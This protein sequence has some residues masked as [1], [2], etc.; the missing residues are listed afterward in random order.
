MSTKLP[1]SEIIAR[2]D[3]LKPDFD[4]STL[5]IAQMLGVFGFHNIMYPHPTT[6]AKLVQLFNEQLKPQADKFRLER[7]SRQNSLASTE[8][9]TDGLTGRPLNE[10]PRV[11]LHCLLSDVIPIMLRSARQDLLRA[12][13]Q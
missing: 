2:G 8:G 12:E 11:R 9:I 7:I 10:G 3:Y 13:L 1:A 4:P 5:T 6:K